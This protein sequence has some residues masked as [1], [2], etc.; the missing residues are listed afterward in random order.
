M[1]EYHVED[2]V[3]RPCSQVQYYVT[4]GNLDQLLQDRQFASE[5][6]LDERIVFES[7]QCIDGCIFWLLK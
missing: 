5:A 2:A 4:V 3:L 1:R 6:L 7:F